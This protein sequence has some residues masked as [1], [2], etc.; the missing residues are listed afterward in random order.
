MT[1]SRLKRL[2]KMVLDLTPRMAGCPACRYRAL[3]LVD[4]VEMGPPSGIWTPD[5]RCKKCGGEPERRY[6]IHFERPRKKRRIAPAGVAN[7]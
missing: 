4:G 7:R 1:N 3:V 2:E 6:E 5:G